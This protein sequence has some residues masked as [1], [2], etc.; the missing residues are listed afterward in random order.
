MACPAADAISARCRSVRTCRAAALRRVRSVGRAASARSL[1]SAW[2][3][4]GGT[5]SAFGSARGSVD[6]AAGGIDSTPRRVNSAAIRGSVRTA[7]TKR[8]L[9]EC[10]VRQCEHERRGHCDCLNRIHRIGPFGCHSSWTTRR[11]RQRSGSA[12]WGRRNS[13]AISNSTAR[14]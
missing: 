6:G 3:A 2:S 13:C 7:A 14:K 11:V 5:G 10:I 4:F 9:G 1:D 8:G 12:R